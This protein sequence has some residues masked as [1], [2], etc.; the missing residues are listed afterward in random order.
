MLERRSKRRS[1]KIITIYLRKSLRQKYNNMALYSIMVNVSGFKSHS[2]YNLI[3]VP[4]YFTII[5]SNFS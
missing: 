1:T 4:K 5:V 2:G 3:S